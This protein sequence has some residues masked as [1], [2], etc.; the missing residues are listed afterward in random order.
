MGER[1]SCF[2]FEIRKVFNHLCDRIALLLRHP[3]L[4][5]H[6][7]DLSLFV[8]SPHMTKCLGKE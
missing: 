2:G 5:Y 6:L 3:R 1:Q 4:G 7:L 8:L